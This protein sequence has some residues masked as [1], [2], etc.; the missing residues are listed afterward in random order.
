MTHFVSHHFVLTIL[1]AWVLMAGCFY[2]SV[3]SS[4]RRQP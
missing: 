4:L 1:L 3:K 2:L